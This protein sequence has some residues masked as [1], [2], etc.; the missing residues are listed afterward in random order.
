MLKLRHKQVLR[1]ISKQP[2]APLLTHQ[3]RKV[4]ADL[5]HMGYLTWDGK[6]RC[7]RLTPEA[8]KVISNA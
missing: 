6:T 7:Y 3:R 8:E 5:Y 1:G 2:E 4:A